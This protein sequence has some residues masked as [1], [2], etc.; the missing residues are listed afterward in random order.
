MV[1]PDGGQSIRLNGIAPTG[2]SS[3]TSTGSF[4]P[5]DAAIRL[6]HPPFSLGYRPL[7][8][9][10]SFSGTV[11]DSAG[12]VHTANVSGVA[13]S[14]GIL[15]VTFQNPGVDS[16]YLSFGTGKIDM[17]KPFPDT[18]PNPSYTGSLSSTGTVT[19]TGA[20]AYIP[21]PNVARTYVLRVCFRGQCSAPDI[22]VLGG[23]MFSFQNFR[24]WGEKDQPT[25]AVAA[26][27]ISPTLSCST[28]DPSQ[29]VFWTGACLAGTN[30]GLVAWAPYGMSTTT[31]YYNGA[32]SLEE[33]ENSL[34]DTSYRPYDM[35]Y[36]KFVDN[37]T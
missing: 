18:D 6:Q 7:A 25:L 9:K 17:D 10:I 29:S 1:V 32:H 36:G 23:D 33:T 21:D 16:Y 11:S 34:N 20:F 3:P 27:T 12:T 30:S 37:A 15:S 4:T 13:V 5:A 24:L 8:D 2:S 31:I 19:I 14:T 26:Q 28:A 35:T 22:K